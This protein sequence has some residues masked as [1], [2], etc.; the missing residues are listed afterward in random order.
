MASVIGWVLVV[1]GVG[2][3]VAAFVNVRDA[4]RS[5]RWPMAVAE[6]MRSEVD[7]IEAGDR[8]SHRFVVA[9]GR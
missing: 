4:N 8:G 2:V 3:L 9:S 5:R 1:V 7:E 6:I